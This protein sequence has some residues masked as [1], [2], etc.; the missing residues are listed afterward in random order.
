MA[1][2]R[3]TQKES[4]PQESSPRDL[5][6][7]FRQGLFKNLL[8]PILPVSLLL[9]FILPQLSLPSASFGQAA[10]ADLFVKKAE[11][12][13]VSKA[14]EAAVPRI[15]PVRAEATIKEL[16]VL[17]FNLE[18]L[19][20]S[21][22]ERPMPGQEDKFRQLRS[23][24]SEADPDIAILP[25]VASPTAL[26][27][28]NSEQL[29]GRYHALLPKGAWLGAEVGFLIRSDLPWS[30]RVIS[31]RDLEWRNR[32][33]GAVQPLF[34]HDLPVLEL[35]RRIDD[36]EPLFVVIGNHAKAKRDSAG[37]R[38]SQAWRTAEYQEAARIIES[39]I[40]RRVPVLFGG[41]FNVDVLNDPVLRPLKALMGSA[42]AEAPDAV[43]EAERVT[44]TFH[45]A[46]AA[47]MKTQMDDVFVSRGLVRS[48]KSARILRYRDQAGRIRA[49]ADSI[50]QRQRQP[51]DH[52]PVALTLSTEELLNRAQ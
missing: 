47:S 43:P 30:V 26:A 50:E 1:R 28:L 49:I 46:G 37:D 24:I 27:V 32:L 13:S 17:A 48:I 25:E 38:E 42:L 34:P 9:V 39:Y 8:M 4:S 5:R 33:T 10:C 19:L 23:I 21:K 15:S 12:K 40:E 6:Q 51:S 41:D 29:T 20:A 45:P 16:S 3:P 35:R 44:H 36:H 52:L 14:A 11:A 18:N 31:H 22:N 7:R 2:F